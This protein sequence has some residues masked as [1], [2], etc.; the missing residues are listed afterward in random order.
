MVGVGEC[1]LVLGRCQPE[2][3][4]SNWSDLCPVYQLSSLRRHGRQA[5]KSADEMKLEI[6]VSPT[7]G[8][9]HLKRSYKHLEQQIELNKKKKNYPEYQ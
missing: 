4:A 9:I 6:I 3:S 7:D 1:F 2:G 5:F 8:K